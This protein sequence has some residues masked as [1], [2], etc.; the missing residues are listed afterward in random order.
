MLKKIFMG[1]SIL[2]FLSGCVQS[3]ALI[4]PAY[5]L[6]ASGNIYQA[7]LSYSSNQAITTLTGKSTGENIIDLLKPKKQDTDFEKFVKKRIKKTRKILNIS[8]Q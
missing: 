1:V 8:N 3:T 7:G 4:G 2:C 5:T 6:G